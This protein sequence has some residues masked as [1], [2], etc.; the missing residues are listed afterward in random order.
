M[1]ISIFTRFLPSGREEPAEDRAALLGH[2]TAFD[3]DRVLQHLLLRVLR[4][5]NHS[6]DPCVKHRSDAHLAGLERHIQRGAG[7]SVVLEGKRSGAHRLDFGVCGRIVRRDRPIPSLAENFIL[8]NDQRA[9]RHLALVLRAFRKLQGAAHV[10]FVLRHCSIVADSVSRASPFQVRSFR[11]QWPADL[12]TSW[13]FEMEALI[14]GWYVLSTTGSVEQLA[15]GAAL[16]W[17]GSLFSP[18]F[19]LAGDRI[20]HRNVLCITRSVY[21]LL[22]ATLTALTLSGALQTWHIFA[23][24]RKSTR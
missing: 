7:E 17:L 9:D 3:P 18:F 23:I 4:A 13:A 19:G 12:L 15:P 11:F 10:L 14:L 21:A 20:G 16:V 1:L 2:E 22:A 5:V 8:E 6:C 24:D